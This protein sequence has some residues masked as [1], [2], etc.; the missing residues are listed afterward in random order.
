MSEW[1]TLIKALLTSSLYWWQVSFLMIIFFIFV[2]KLYKAETGHT[3]QGKIR[4]VYY[5]F[6]YLLLGT[7]L[8]SIILLQVSMPVNYQENKTGLESALSIFVALF[9]SD[10]FYYWYHRA[11]HAMP[12]LWA[13]HEL[14]H[15]DSEMNATTSWRTHF[16]EQ[17]VQLIVVSLPGLYLLPAIIHKTTG[18][19]SFQLTSTELVIYTIIALIFLIGSHANI[20]WQLGKLT[21]VFTAPQYH[22]LHHSIERKHYDKNF[23]QYFPLFD[24]LFGTYCAPKKDEFPKTGTPELASD[25]SLFM[26]LIR[27]FILWRNKVL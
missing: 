18:V 27:P 20:R 3:V 15:A 12:F 19:H 25:A 26:T 24:K 23:A 17:P 13:I 7:L 22:R 14:H 1:L 4:N 2:E 9:V 5:S 6:F 21:P 10:F 16:L 8:A 11:Q